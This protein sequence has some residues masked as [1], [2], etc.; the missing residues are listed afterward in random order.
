M[1]KSGGITIEF[2]AHAGI[3]SFIYKIYKQSFY[4]KWVECFQNGLTIRPCYVVNVGKQKVV[5][6]L[7]VATL[8]YFSPLLKWLC[9]HWPGPTK[10]LDIKYVLCMSNTKYDW[11]N[12]YSQD[13]KN[14]DCL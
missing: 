13:L 3:W 12:A 6:K 4:C 5:E 10:E 2:I 7:N 8:G 1:I 14:N 11:T 9:D